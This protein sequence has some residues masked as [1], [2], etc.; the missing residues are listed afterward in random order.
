MLD[1]VVFK[2]WPGS[3][4]FLMAPDQRTR[5]VQIWPFNKW[6]SWKETTF[7]FFYD[8][9]FVK[10][11]FWSAELGMMITEWIPAPISRSKQST[12]IVLRQMSESL[13]RTY[14]SFSTFLS[15]K[16]YIFNALLLYEEYF[17]CCFNV[18]QQTFLVIKSMHLSHGNL[19]TY[20]SLIC[21]VL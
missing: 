7:S 20:I 11:V 12:K 10:N 2:V 5:M 8:E 18:L 19:T 15:L 9:T 17:F 14:N 21:P 16:H 6:S 13:F 1:A 3:P 4:N